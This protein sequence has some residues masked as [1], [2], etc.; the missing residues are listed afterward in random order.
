MVATCAK[1]PVRNTFTSLRPPTVTYANVPLALC[2]MLTWLVI[3]PVSI[4]F[5]SANGGRPSKT[6]VRPVSLSVNQTCEPSGVVAMFG[7]NGLACTTRPTIA[8]D[9]TSTATVSGVSEEQ[10]YPY[11]PSGENIVIPGPF[12]TAIRSF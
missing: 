12:G 6:C 2:T 7:Q 10:T 5:R 11:F 4:V 9:A 3:G 8:W 1:S